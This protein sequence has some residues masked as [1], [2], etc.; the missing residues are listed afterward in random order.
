MTSEDFKRGIELLDGWKL[1]NPK[2]AANRKS[3]A[4]TLTG[5]VYRSVVE[6]KTA[7]ARLKRSTAPPQF[8]SA[9]SPPQKRKEHEQFKAPDLPRVSEQER[10]ENLKKLETLLTSVR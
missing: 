4:R 2:K 10:R 7:E 1:D 5:W 3:D 6:E 8:V 9:V